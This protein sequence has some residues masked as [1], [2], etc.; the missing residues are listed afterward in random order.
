MNGAL[1]LVSP[2]T[3]VRRNEFAEFVAEVEP[4]LR[5]ALI[6][7]IGADRTGDAVAHALAWAWEHWDEVALLANPAGYLY[8]VARNSA[9]PAPLGRVRWL[10]HETSRIPDVEP[11]LGPALSQLSPQQRSAVWL[12]YACRWSYA[13]AAEAL[14]ITPSALGTH[15]T[16]GM[17]KLRTEIVGEDR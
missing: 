4:R 6:G 16:R 11:R 3:A 2:T 7:A 10:I 5:R 8:R 9:T 17:E 13:E 15:L 14:E 1:M 12:V